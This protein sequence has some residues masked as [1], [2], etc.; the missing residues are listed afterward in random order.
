MLKQ[1]WGVGILLM[2][3]AVPV[4]ML[5]AGGYQPLKQAL[6][7]QENRAQHLEE[8]V[9]S[10][11]PGQR[12]LRN[13]QVE[14][15]YWS[16]GKE[17]NDI[18]IG[19][20]RLMRNVKPPENADSLQ[21]NTETVLKLAKEF[22]RPSYLMLI[23]TACAVQQSEVPY[24]SVAP[25]Y[26]QRALIDTIYQKMAGNVTAVDVYPTLFNHQ[27]EYI[28]YRTD[29]SPSGMGGYYIYSALAP[30][31][32]ISNVRGI[33]QFSV[34]H[35]DYSYLGDLY[36]LSPYHAVEADRVSTY[37]Y[38]RSWHS[39]TMTHYD[40]QGARKYF[41]LYPEFKKELGDGMDIILGGTS[42]IVDI[43]M[44]NSLNNLR[45]L[46]LGDRSMQSYLPFLLNHY[47]RITFVDTAQITPEI[48]ENISLDRYSQVL[49]AY[50][51][52][53]FMEQPQLETVAQAWMKQ[54]AKTNAG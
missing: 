26:N 34:A 50:T 52:D 36:V 31:L 2:L 41:T 53:Q 39:Y 44:G 8:T 38:S 35:V 11:M 17:Q 33:E 43:E 18:F 15:A 49:F 6:T 37:Q 48:L 45:L 32:G 4:W 46:V 14:M 25:L 20:N 27:S 42:P 28:Y 21:N 40:A 23:P 13:L 51:V 19:D 7:A 30:K 29:S 22:E 1:L 9:K 12:W 10:R 3:L 24:N 47:S 16:G 5:N 54:Q